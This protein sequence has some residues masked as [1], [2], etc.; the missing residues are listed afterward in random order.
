METLGSFIRIQDVDTF[1][2]CP[3]CRISTPVV[4][5]VWD[6]GNSILY[7]GLLSATVLLSTLILEAGGPNLDGSVSIDASSF[8]KQN[9]GALRIRMVT[10]LSRRIRDTVWSAKWLC[11]RSRNGPDPTN[12]TAC[13]PT[14]R[15]L[16][17]FV[18]DRLI[19]LKLSCIMHEVA[20]RRRVSNLSAFH[21]WSVW[22]GWFLNPVDY[23][24]WVPDI[25]KQL[26]GSF[27][28]SKLAWNGVGVSNPVCNA[29][30]KG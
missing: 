11:P 21:L 26:Q 18:N 16:N 20:S 28:R 19:Q 9:S 25:T 14:S 12:T 7:H 2:G 22:P 5:M 3:N 23:F 24:V 17:L 10:A 6:G 13:P 1:H 27:M 8:A 29:S 30:I 15:T 4:F